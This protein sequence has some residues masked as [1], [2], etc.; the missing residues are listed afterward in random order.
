MTAM[1]GTTKRF[2]IHEELREAILQKIIERISLDEIERTDAVTL[3]EEIAVIAKDELSSTPLT[4][5]ERQRIVGE[6]INE[7]TGFGPI[8]P[9]LKDQTISDIIVNGPADVFIERYGRLERVKARFRGREHLMHTIR[10]LVGAAGRRIDESAPMVDAFLSDNSRVNAIIPP[11]A[12]AP[13]VSIRKFMR[14]VTGLKQM[15]DI[16]S[17]SAEMG[18]F[19]RLCIEGKLNILVSGGTGTGK[20]TL[21]NAISKFIPQSERIITVEDSFELMISQPNMVRLVTRLPNVEGKGGVSQRQLVIN[22]L[23]MRPDRIIVGE[24]RGSEVWDMLQAMNTGHAGSITTVHANSA[25]DSLHR[26]ETMAMLTGYEITEATLKAIISRSIDIVIHLARF[27]TGERKIIQITEIVGV[28]NNRFIIDDIFRFTPGPVAEGRVTGN[29]HCMK[30]S[31][32]NKLM[33]KIALSGMQTD[34]IKGILR[35]G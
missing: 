27:V 17:I 13:S 25:L 29:F 19:L 26:L 10:K 30:D 24:V 18:E 11:V 2:R 23:R 4:F 21:L 15:I 6:I 31:L 14:S 32:S 22:C 7:L 5:H 33:D 20:T 3:R 28:E 35:K 34:A 9:L 16:G 1:E 12:F 8:E